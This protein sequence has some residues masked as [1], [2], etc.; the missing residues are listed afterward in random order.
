M[1]VG[2]C[3]FYDSCQNSLG[4]FDSSCYQ[5]DTKLYYFFY[6]FSTV[7]MYDCQ[8][9]NKNCKSWNFGGEVER[10]LWNTFSP[11]YFYVGQIMVVY[12]YGNVMHS[13]MI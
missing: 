12:Q 5:F 7:K 13:N 1:F 4:F 3:K 11:Q 8:N 10:V 6:S 9:P 2:F